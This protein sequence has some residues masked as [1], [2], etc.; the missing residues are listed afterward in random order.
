MNEPVKSTDSTSGRR[1]KRR[2]AFVA[3]AVACSVLP[4]LVLEGSLRLLNIGAADTDVHD[5]IDATGTLFEPDGSGNLRTSLSRARFFVSQTFPEQHESREFRIFVLGGSTVQ[6]RP[7]SAETSFCQWLQLFLQNRDSSR[8]YRCVNCGGISYASDRLTHVLNEVL[9]YQPDLIVLAT[10]HNE[11]LEDRTYAAVREKSTARKWL[12]QAAGASRTVLVVR[13]LCG[14]A[15][16]I[17]PDH[18]TQTPAEDVETRLDDAAGYASYHRD[19]EW[20][21][22]VRQQFQKSLTGMIHQ[23]GNV[24]VPLV[25]VKLGSNL[26]DC[27]PFKSEL[28]AAMSA[29]Q[30]QQW[31]AVFD[32]A[33]STQ[34]QNPQQA[35]ELYQQ[36]VQIDPDH[37]LTHFRMAEC[38]EVMSDEKRSLAEYIAARDLDVC[39]LRM[40]SSLQETLTMVATE[41]KVSLVDGEAA[42]QR[43][44]ESLHNIVTGY[45]TYLD[46]VHPT[47]AGHQAIAAELVRHLAEGGFLPQESGADVEQNAGGARAVVRKQMASLPTAYFSNGRRRIGWLEGWAQRQRLSAEVQPVDAQEHARSAMRY[48]ELD[49][50]SQARRHLIDALD[51]DETVE[52]NL[53][54]HARSF[55]LA[56]MTRPAAW[57]LDELEQRGVKTPGVQDSIDVARLV[58]A[59]DQNYPDAITAAYARQESRWP[60]IIAADET[61]WREVVPDL[62]DRATPKP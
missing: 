36:A 18:E 34:D 31:Q 39:P 27:P 42:V 43:L 10:G 56:G 24:G 35:L 58:M 38:L 11:F 23:C 44:S 51:L 14:F 21:Q 25:L 9:Q 54:R 4:F 33:T 59:V 29:E 41:Q 53:L 15:P 20:Q 3:A 22:Q 32:R 8:N 40:S 28:P 50:R 37:A 26:R 13:R 48:L 1:R 7:F 12:E 16:R 30:Q 19:P 49:E 47:I 2:W 45:D 60:D 57:V 6:G 62:V 17:E 52:R 55:Y 5:G 46:H 61:G